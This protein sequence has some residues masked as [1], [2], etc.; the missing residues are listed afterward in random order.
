[1]RWSV[2][3]WALLFVASWAGFGTAWASEF[4]V[5]A[6]VG[7]SIRNMLSVADIRPASRSHGIAGVDAR[8]AGERWGIG[9][10]AYLGG[11]WFDFHQQSGFPSGNIKDQCWLIRPR[12]ERLLSIDDKTSLVIGTG[13][14]YGEWR[15][16]T[17][18]RLYSARGPRA[19]FTGGTLRLGIEH[20][21]G[22]F[23]L[24]GAVEGSVFRSHASDEEN[25]SEY[26]WVGSSFSL[27]IGLRYVV[28]RRDG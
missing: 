28:A 16:W 19:F 9:V 6:E 13:V 22:R 3:P 4:A 18:T 12:V 10:G 25:A 5:G 24:H 26:H 2:A 7:P 8:L 15:S 1:M 21:P 17:D 27:M 11:T 23:E 14:E 20:H